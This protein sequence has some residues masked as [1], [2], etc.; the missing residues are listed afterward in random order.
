MLKNIVLRTYFSKKTPLYA[1]F[2]AL[3]GVFFIIISNIASAAWTPP[4]APAPGE[5][6]GAP[7]TT[8]SAA[9][10]KQGSLTVGGGLALSGNNLFLPTATTGVFWD[11]T[12][13]T[14]PHLNYADN[15]VSRLYL[16]AG[17][18]GNGIELQGDVFITQAGANPPGTLTIASPDLM[19]C[20]GANAIKV[21][22]SGKLVCAVDELGLGGTLTG[23]GADN[24]VSVFQDA[25]TLTYDDLFHWD[26]ANHRLGIGTN[27]PQASLQVDGTVRLT[28]LQNC[29]TFDT[30][31]NGNLSCGIDE[32]GASGLWEESFGAGSWSA[33]GTGLNQV[34]LDSIIYNGDLIVSGMFTQAGGVA[35][36]RIA[37]WDGTTWSPLG[38]GLQ[39]CLWP[40]NDRGSSLVIY[41]GELVVGGCFTDA[42]GVAVSNIA[43]WNGANWSAL[44]A[45]RGNWVEALTVFNGNLI[46]GQSNPPLRSNT[47]TQ[48]N[49]TAWS[50]FPGWNP[51]GGISIVA[52]TVY[53]DQLIASGSIDY[54]NDVNGD[55]MS[56]NGSTWSIIGSY[57]SSCGPLACWVYDFE[58]YN[59][60]L[61]VGGRFNING[62]GPNVAAWNGTA[63]SPLGPGMPSEVVYNLGAY[64]GMLYTG[65]NLF[66]PSYVHRWN[67]TVWST[68]G[69]GANSIVRTFTTYNGALYVGGQFTQAGGQP[70]NGIAKWLE[71]RTINPS[72]PA[73]TKVAIGHSAVDDNTQLS[74]KSNSPNAAIYGE[75][76]NPGGT[77]GLFSGRVVM[78]GGNFGIK[79]DSPASVLT[80]GAGDTFQ[81]DI[82]GDLKRINSVSYSWPNNQGVADTYLKNDGSGNLSW[83]A[84]PAG[85]TGTGAASRVAFW[86]NNTVLGSHAN[87]LWDNTNS[88]LGIGDPLPPDNSLSVGDAHNFGVD[89]NGNLVKINGKAYSWP[90]NQG[91]A[92]TYLRNDGSG[93]LSWSAGPSDAF[94]VK[95]SN[96]DAVAGFLNQEILAGDNIAF[97]L[98]SPGGDERLSI[99][100]TGGSS[101]PAGAN[102]QTLRYNAAWVASPNLYNTG[103]NVG[104]NITGPSFPDGRF[105]VNHN[106]V[107][108]GSI[109]DAVDI[110]ADSNNSALYAQQNGSGQA[111][112][113]SGKTVVMNGKVGVNVTDPDQTYTQVGGNMVHR[114]SGS[115]LSVIGSYD[116]T[117]DDI[118]D[119][120]KITGK[121]AYVLFHTFLDIVDISN[122]LAPIRIGRYSGNCGGTG[123]DVV[124]KYAYLACADSGLRIIDISNSS[125]PVQ[126]GLYNSPGDVNDVVV[127]GRYAY[128]ADQYPGIKV[129]NISNPAAPVLTGSVDTNRAAA[130]N[131]SGKYLYV[132]DDIN[133]T[134]PNGGL[135]IVDVSNPAAPVIVGQVTTPQ[136]GFNDIAI[137]GKYAY[138]AS[139]E[140]SIV[141]TPKVYVYN[142]GN[143]AAPVFV[144]TWSSNPNSFS[145]EARGKYV[146]LNTRTFFYV[147]N[148]SDPANI[149]NVGDTQLGGNYNG[150]DI[151]GKYAYTGRLIGSHGY[152]KVIDLSGLDTPAISTG[153]VVTGQLD[154]IENM[155]VGNNLTVRTG[156]NVGRFGI[157]ADGPIQAGDFAFWNNFYLTELG[158]SGVAL[159][160]PD[161]TNI[162]SF[163]NSGAG[164]GT[165]PISGFQLTVNGDLATTTL[166]RQLNTPAQTAVFKQA[167]ETIALL[168]GRQYL[169]SRT[170]EPR[171]GLDASEIERLLPGLIRTGNN[172]EKHVSYSQLIPILVE[173]VKEQQVQ[174]SDLEKLIEKQ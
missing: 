91:A 119:G 146:Y 85:I 88:R 2:L 98:V 28:S 67:G 71:P 61:V 107:G 54:N 125:A 148:V 155:D 131:I 47:I 89:A 130:V 40:G 39:G 57:S 93:N 31:A 127:S 80:V 123:L 142:V 66:D 133:M 113:F 150:L 95:I 10:I 63:W 141:G 139:S 49:G 83:A 161:D 152:M 121:F 73:T 122:P 19:G 129:I 99:R 11:D 33:L 52:L 108:A 102:G 24:K 45:G 157:K 1:L 132:A 53:D 82:F 20:N 173:A 14:K 43:K 174:I 103:T 55:V 158:E 72:N 18:S 84:M 7:L 23:S 162:M 126:V 77:A 156:L 109:N 138:L 166:W 46:A 116:P 35:A 29:N 79:D 56:W 86:T 110:F 135:R 140:N 13:F 76:A 75:Q 37:R 21:D 64:N 160:N 69:T 120:I 36:N 168:R 112:Y 27:S 9:Q 137:S 41:N 117:N 171:L 97:T 163:T 128:I 12:L 32:G 147:L 134:T 114:Y 34:V 167:V 106:L 4:S 22:A 3:F 151:Q 48:W 51:A 81:V 87:F 101:L 8:S 136:I 169:D 17:E 100:N 104:I 6:T 50:A 144:S 105:V 15:P 165:D 44:G 172:D 96:D 16:S 143:P 159:R 149:T 124:G 94:T 154:V 60:T 62:V 78:M 115:Q 5:N 90:A 74:I 26:R 111:G 170:N 118:I 68:P 65:D 164:L 70:A 153:S 145:I 38:S 92:N 25:N 42:G 59:N 30:D 58:T